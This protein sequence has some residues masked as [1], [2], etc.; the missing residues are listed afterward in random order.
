MIRVVT[1]A[2]EFGSGGSQVAGELARRLQ[3]KLV[4]GAIIDEI[5]QSSGVDVDVAKL[6]DE[7]VDS[8]FHRMF[9]GLWHGGFEGSVSTT[10]ASRVSIF[11][12]E[13]MARLSH[14][15]I[16]KAGAEGNCIIV[17]RGGQCVLQKRTDTMN[18]F[19]YAP[20]GEKVRRVRE[21]VP[22]NVDVEGTIH[23]MD[24]QRHTYIRQHFNQDWSDRHL[25][26]AMLSS[27]L[28]VSVVVDCIVSA[29]EHGKG[30]C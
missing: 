7:R 3:W 11:D 24:R 4:D 29:M 26:H 18:F 8:A 20:W 25:Y 10:A 16:E 13:A 6:C 27:C 28:G 1:I 5:V 21:R 19:I 14:S 2:R 9:K 22:A 15:I 17:G 12:S 23:K 30:R